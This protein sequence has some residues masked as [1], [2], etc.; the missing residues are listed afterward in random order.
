MHKKSSQAKLLKTDKAGEVFNVTEKK[1][2]LKYYLDL[3]LLR[4]YSWKKFS[5]SKKNFPRM[6]ENVLE[7]RS[8]PSDSEFLGSNNSV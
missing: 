3:V 5:V 6:K 7:E 1:D 8:V 2:F 4:L